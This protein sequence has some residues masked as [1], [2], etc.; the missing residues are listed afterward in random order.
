MSNRPAPQSYVARAD[1]GCI[2]LF[3]SAYPEAIKD[4]AKYVAAAMVRGY[5]LERVA[6]GNV[7]AT[8][9]SSCEA[10][11]ELVQEALV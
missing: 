6:L 7:D 1:C 9:P 2:K 10:C 4:I 5:T 8:E 11:A 3:V